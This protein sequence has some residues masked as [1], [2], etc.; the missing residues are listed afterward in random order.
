MQ[1]ELL[2]TRERSPIRHNRRE[3]ELSI[4]IVISALLVHNGSF[5]LLA[6]VGCLVL[7][8]ID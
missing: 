8:H 7:L 5:W 3:E 6:G 1:G 2:G 4:F